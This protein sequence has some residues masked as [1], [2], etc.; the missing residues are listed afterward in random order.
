MVKVG[1]SLGQSPATE[2]THL[3]LNQ[4]PVFPVGVTLAVPGLS[5]DSLPPSTPV[6]VYPRTPELHWHSWDY[7]GN[8]WTAGVTWDRAMDVGTEHGTIQHPSYCVNK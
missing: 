8:P 3:G 7:S 1:G 6:A 2:I 4:L 5:W